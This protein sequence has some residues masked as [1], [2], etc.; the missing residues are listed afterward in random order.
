MPPK[1]GAQT[2]SSS[3][4]KE[5]KVMSKHKPPTGSEFV[6]LDRHSV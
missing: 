2:S 5:D 3:K 4:V 6:F 1:K